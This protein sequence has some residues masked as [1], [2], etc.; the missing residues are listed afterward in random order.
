M[1]TGS[2]EVTQLVQDILQPALSDMI[3]K[4]ECQYL[5]MSA[6]ETYPVFV[7]YIKRPRAGKIMGEPRSICY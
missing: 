5:S 4:R 3:H 7:V 1:Q 2:A 6:T